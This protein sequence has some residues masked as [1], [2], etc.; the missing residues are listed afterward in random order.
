MFKEWADCE[1]IDSWLQH[2]ELCFVSWFL[3]CSLVIRNKRKCL[4]MIDSF[5]SS[6]FNPRSFLHIGKTME[7]GVT[8]IFEYHPIWDG[9]LWWGTRV[10]LTFLQDYKIISCLNVRGGTKRDHRSVLFPKW[11]EMDLNGAPPCFSVYFV[12]DMFIIKNQNSAFTCIIFKLRVIK[13]HF[14][15]MSN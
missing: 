6:F 1:K 8:F 14:N 2:S 15:S 4:R 11:K 12:F 5:S 3:L 7:F 10:T 13:C 9:W